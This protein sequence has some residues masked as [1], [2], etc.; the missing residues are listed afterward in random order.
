MVKFHFRV[1]VFLN[2]KTHYN[3]VLYPTV[4]KVGSIRFLKCFRMKNYIQ[5]ECYEMLI[6]F[7]CILAEFKKRINQTLNGGIVQYEICKLIIF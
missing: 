1:V 7:K 6:Q 4:Q 5:N 3:I 2:A